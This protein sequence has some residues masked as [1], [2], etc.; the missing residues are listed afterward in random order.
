MIWFLRCYIGGDEWSMNNSFNSSFNMP[1]VV[2]VK[3]VK[4]KSVEQGEAANKEERR[5]RQNQVLRRKGRGG[6]ESKKRR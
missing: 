3:K 2:V 6:S 4:A 1:D 5:K